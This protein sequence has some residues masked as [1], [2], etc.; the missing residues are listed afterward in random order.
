MSAVEQTLPEKIRQ[1]RAQMLVHSCIYYLYDDSLVSDHT[2]Q[3]W[4]DEL[5]ALQREHLS[6]IGF[7]DAEFADWDASTGYHLPK[8]EWVTSKA[9]QLIRHRD[10]TTT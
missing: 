1:R 10:F 5:V 3:Q 9:L 4:A 6:P 2:W 7:Y 8:D